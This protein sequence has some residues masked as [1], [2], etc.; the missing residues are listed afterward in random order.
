L[1]DLPIFTRVFLHIKKLFFLLSS[2][3]LVGGTFV[4][5]I[6]VEALEKRLS[7]PS[8]LIGDPGF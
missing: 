8:A 3:N 7:S 4:N 1:L 2:Q 5:G 6:T